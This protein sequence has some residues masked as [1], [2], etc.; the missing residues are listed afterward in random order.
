MEKKKRPKLTQYTYLVNGLLTAQ[1]QRKGYI[2]EDDVKNAVE[3]TVKAYDL[4]IE[5]VGEDDVDEEPTVSNAVEVKD[6][7]AEFPWHGTGH[8]YS[9][10][11]RWLKEQGIKS[12]RKISLIFNSSI[13]NGFIKKSGGGKYAKY[14]Y[15]GPA[16]F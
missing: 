7:F 9:E 12:N 15:I 13:E 14:I 6:Y 1:I 3:T 5:A 8:S 2:D 10:L 4:I 16:P 11:E